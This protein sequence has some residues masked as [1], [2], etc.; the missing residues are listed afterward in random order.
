[1]SRINCYSPLRTDFYELTMMQ[2][3]FKEQRDSRAVFD[4][5]F[6]RNPFNGGYAIFAGLDTLLENL[7]NLRFQED[8]LA[9]LRSLKQFDED[10]LEYLSQFRFNGDIFSMPE[11]SL[12]FANEPILRIEGTLLETQL[13]EPMLLNLL[14]FQTLIATK[15]ARVFEASHHGSIMEFG[16]RRAHGPNGALYASRAAFIGGASASSNVEAG[17]LFHIPVRGTMAHSWIMSYPDELSAF[18]A[19]ARLY[20]ENC[21]LLVDTYHTLES[22]LPNALIVLNELKA[23]GYEGFGIRLDSGDLDFLS[24]KARKIL[25]EGGV[26][27]ARITVSNELDEYV[28]DHLV[29]ENAPIDKWGVGTRMVT[30][31]DDASLSGVY[32]LA[33]RQSNGALLP[34]MK[35]TNN[36]EKMSNPGVKNTARFFDETGQALADLVFLESERESLEENISKRK[37]ILFHHPHIDYAQFTLK[38][39]ARSEILL[40]PVMKSGQPLQ[41]KS[42]LPNLQKRCKSSLESLDG[43]SKRLLNPHIYKVSISS[44]LKE[45]KSEF[46]KKQMT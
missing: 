5:F 14:N 30:G 36:P 32:K 8:E 21:T 29:H 31:G 2:G 10:F 35:L 17:Y 43:T 38:N 4:Y 27:E 7:Q 11:G 6:R 34:A 37:P 33:A 28:I 24:K 45:M 1:M 23:A 26:P 9:Y 20:P 39:Y 13:I 22:G 18:R 19:Y 25:N 3:Y 42:P 40:Q 44:N 12:A 16:L 15:T 46:I 41:D